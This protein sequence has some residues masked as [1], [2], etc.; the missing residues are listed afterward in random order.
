MSFLGERNAIAIG[1]S[2][3]AVLGS[4]P[5]LTRLS[6]SL[7]L[8]FAGAESLDPRVTF[9]RASTAT[10]TNPSGIIESVST[11]TARFD[12]NPTTLAPK[13]LLIEESRTNLLTYSEQFDNA[14]WTKSNAAV[15][16]T[17]TIIAPDGT[18]TAEEVRD[19]TA[20]NIHSAFQGVTLASGTTY[21]AS[22][23]LKNVDRQY[24]IL[25]VSGGVSAY[26]SAKFDLIGGTSTANQA[27]GAGWSVTSVAMTPVGSDWYRCVLVFVSGTSGS[28]NVRIGLASDGTTFTTSGSGLQS[29][30][31]T[32]LKIAVWGAQ[33]ETGAFATSYIP[34]VASQVTRAADV[35]TMT[36]TN[37]SSWYNATEGTLFADFSWEGL[38][39]VAGQR[40]IVLDDGTTATYWGMSATSGNAMQNPVSISSTTEAVNATPS[41]GYTALTP[42]KQ[43]VA[44]A[45]NNSVGA[46]NGNS[47]TTDTAVGVPSGL[48]TTR[49]AASSTA[50]VSNIWFRKIA[51]YPRRLTN[52]E[53]QGI[54]A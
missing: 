44:L 45:L 31:G 8:Q 53:L 30:T 25:A 52:A 29:Y 5:L 12:Y 21:V 38:R 2:Q 1:V 37:F 43:A 15:S 9:T 42:Y 46:V 23:F 27:S 13:G 20:T 18:T 35:A 7:L 26:A 39:S 41:T 10:R 24:A 50:V 54:T 6:P 16:G 49:F 33:L 17:N 51:Y 32:D 3:H 11:N 47:G 36:G 48:T 28:C 19:G 40:I 34:T 4:G 22:V 14:A